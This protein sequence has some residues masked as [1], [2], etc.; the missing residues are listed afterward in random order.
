M[1]A[2]ANPLQ[3][4]VYTLLVADTGVGGL[5]ATGAPLI[6]AVYDQGS[7][8]EGAT[9]PYISFADMSSRRWGTF[10]RDGEDLE[11]TID[12]WTKE[13]GFKT[14]GVI[15]NRLNVLIGNAKLTVAGYQ[16]A[17][18]LYDRYS[19]IGDP[20]EDIEHVVAVYRVWLQES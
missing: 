10:G 11:M 3:A 13:R 8:L 5:F 18:C 4:A 14:A 1:K 7:V 17:R 9:Y 6:N 20:E 2:A 16:L 15:L 19:R 12:I